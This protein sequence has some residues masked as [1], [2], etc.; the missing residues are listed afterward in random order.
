MMYEKVREEKATVVFMRTE[1]VLLRIA[2]QINGNVSNCLH[3]RSVVLGDPD[4]PEDFALEGITSLW[5]RFIKK[6]ETGIQSESEES[7]FVRG[8]VCGRCKDYILAF[9]RGMDID[10]DLPLV[11]L[12]SIPRYLLDLEPIPDYIKKKMDGGRKVEVRVDEK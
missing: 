2:M 3:G 12:I 10:T 1:H 9:Q 4:Y 8:F 11:E 5:M 6:R 7:R